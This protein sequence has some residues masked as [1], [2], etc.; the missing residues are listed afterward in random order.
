MKLKLRIEFFFVLIWF[1]RVRARSTAGVIYDHARNMKLRCQ[2]KKSYNL[3]RDK[4]LNETIFLS[5]ND[6]LFHFPN[7]RGV[8]QEPGCI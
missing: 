3:N 2:R 7:G 1:L 6:K 5:D 4:T 8:Q